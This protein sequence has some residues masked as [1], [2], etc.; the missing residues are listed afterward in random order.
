MFQMP[1]NHI[2]SRV[3][4]LE[5]DKSQLIRTSYVTYLIYSME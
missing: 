1:Q 5:I 4:G 2:V 3:V